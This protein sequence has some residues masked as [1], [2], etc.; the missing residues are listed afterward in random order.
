MLPFLIS[1]GVAIQ[2]GPMSQNALMTSQPQAPTG[3]QD[4]L[5][6]ESL[7]GKKANSLMG[8]SRRKTVLQEKPLRHDLPKELSNTLGFTK[9]FVF[10]SF[11]L[12]SETLQVL[13]RDLNRVGGV[14]V[15]RGLL[16]GSFLKTAKR[17]RE[18]GIEAEI[19]PTLFRRYKV[20]LVPTFLIE[21]YTTGETRSTSN[22]RLSGNVS[23]S[24]ALSKFLASGQV[25][26]VKNMLGEL[27]NP[28]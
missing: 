28:L 17:I 18:L 11:S 9:L 23:L 21:E 16:D 22:D 24:Y 6:L 3:C 15:F 1:V 2:P 14:M 5:D 4:Q 7:H 8:C 20:Q 12:S 10:V 25:K 13:S 19:D 26:G 27:E